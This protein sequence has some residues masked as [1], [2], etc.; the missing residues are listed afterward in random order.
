MK[1]SELAEKT[2]LTAPTIRFYEKAGL[3]D[4]RHVRRDE[5]NNYR[6]YYEEA[7]EHLLT[8][9]EVQTAGFTLAEFKELDEVCNT[10]ELVVQK[11]TVYIRRKIDAVSEKI[12]ELE[13]VRAYLI[14][15]LA[16]VQEDQ[17]TDQRR[18]ASGG[19]EPS[20]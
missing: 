16:E 6:D 5:G 2:G 14:S 15:K 3:L 12:A 20:S 19:A 8:I 9:K 13:R 4:A 1:I 17:A 18:L 11:A 7:V 10:G